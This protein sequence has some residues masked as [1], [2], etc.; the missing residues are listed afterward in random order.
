M[1]QLNVLVVCTGNVCRSPL[2]EQLLRAH[3]TTAGLNVTVSSAGTGAVEG[4]S[5]D[6]VAAEFS[7]K[8]GGDSHNFTSRILQ[9]ALITQADLIVTATREHR[10]DVARLVPSSAPHTFTIN[11]LARIIRGIPDISA[12]AAPQRSGSSARGIVDYL[13][14]LRGFTVPPSD[15]AEDDIE[16]PFQ[17]SLDF[18]KRVALAI[19]SS[20]KTIVA[21]FAPIA[22]DNTSAGQ[23]V[24]Q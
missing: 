16:D 18:H 17:Q 1:S 10:A 14:A 6:S 23:H 4:H 8:L 21:A 11:E 24:D 2:A 20:V 19:D 3:F 7:Q 12:E 15:G 5:M 22:A 13:T 9:P